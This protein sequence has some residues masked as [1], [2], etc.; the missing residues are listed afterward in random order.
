MAQRNPTVTATD[1]VSEELSSPSAVDLSAAINALNQA[2]QAL[3]T[4]ASQMMQMMQTLASSPGV[5][6]PPPTRDAVAAQ[7]NTL[8]DDPFSEAV[9]TQNPPLATPL[10]V[11]AG[12]RAVTSSEFERRSATS[13]PAST[14][15]IAMR[16][17]T[18]S[19]A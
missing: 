6:Q 15:T 19:P 10:L 5:G 17:S 3:T 2:A 8:E 4:T 18:G 1:A 16:R 11:T 14:Y 12:F 7:I 13:I 9:P